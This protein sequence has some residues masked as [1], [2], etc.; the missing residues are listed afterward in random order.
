MLHNKESLN[1]HY[2]I[3]TKIL[4]NTNQSLQGSL[5]SCMMGVGSGCVAAVAAYRKKMKTTE[6]SRSFWHQSIFE[7][8]SYA[9]LHRSLIFSSCAQMICVATF[10]NTFSIGLILVEKDFKGFSNFMI[11]ISISNCLQYL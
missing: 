11:D 4:G 7:T 1:V 8:S 2:P 3:T 9:L 6:R 10:L 5:T